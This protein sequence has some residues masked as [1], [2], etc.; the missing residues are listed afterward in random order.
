MARQYSPC[1]Y[2]KADF[3]QQ[4]ILLADLT[5]IPPGSSDRLATSLWKPGVI[6]VLALPPKE[7]ANVMC[8]GRV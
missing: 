7:P 1:G 2:R 6:L 8:A 4:F 3:T 5:A